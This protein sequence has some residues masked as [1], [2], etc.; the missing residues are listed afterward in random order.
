[1][2]VEEEIRKEEDGEKGCGVLG[3]QVNKKHS[4]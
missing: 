1:M 4:V 3:L 2:E